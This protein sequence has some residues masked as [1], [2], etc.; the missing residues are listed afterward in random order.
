MGF[1][2][3]SSACSEGLRELG[4]GEEGDKSYES[5]TDFKGENRP[6]MYL[7]PLVASHQTQ[8]NPTIPTYA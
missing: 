3:Y 5:H 7:L 2:G 6:A 1:L 4:V 8:N